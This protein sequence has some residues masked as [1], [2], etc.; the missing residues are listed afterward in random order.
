MHLVSSGVQHHLISQPAQVAVQTTA[1]THPAS[2]SAALAAS[3][4]PHSTSSQGFQS[5]FSDSFMLCLLTD[6]DG[7][8]YAQKIH[9]SESNV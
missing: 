9:N 6:T 5:F 7:Y 4:L 3:R 1:N 8:L 2:T